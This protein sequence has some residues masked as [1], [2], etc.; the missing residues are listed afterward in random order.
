MED[1]LENGAIRL[2]NLAKEQIQ[3][4]RAENHKQSIKIEA[5]ENAVLLVT[6]GRGL[7]QRGWGHE[8]D[9]CK[10]IEDTLYRVKQKKEEKAAL[11]NQ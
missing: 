1:T 7:P 4:L 2:L 5:Y 9:L 10:E 8:S 6:A 3:H 11:A